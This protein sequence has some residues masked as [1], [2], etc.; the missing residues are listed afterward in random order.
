VTREGH[1]AVGFAKAGNLQKAVTPQHESWQALQGAENHAEGRGRMTSP[2]FTVYVLQSLSSPTK[3]YTGI[4]EL[5]AEQR[6]AYHNAGKVDAPHRCSRTEWQASRLPRRFE[7]PVP[8][9]GTFSAALTVRFEVLCFCVLL[10]V[11]ADW[12]MR[13]NTRTGE[14][15]MPAYRELRHKAG[16]PRQR[17]GVDRQ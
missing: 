6:L 13:K 4:T 17:T 5:T 7:L 9:P 10:W 12:D 2:G 16:K 15:C 1:H 14:S 8:W 3:H 11:G